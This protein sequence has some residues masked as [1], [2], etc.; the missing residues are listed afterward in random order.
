MSDDFDLDELGPDF[1]EAGAEAFWGVEIES[2]QRERSIFRSARRVILDG[3]CAQ[4]QLPDGTF[5]AY[6]LA[7]VRKVLAMRLEPRPRYTDEELS[8]DEIY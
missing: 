6:P 7:R 2:S 1:D 3:N 5:E 8:A 4:V